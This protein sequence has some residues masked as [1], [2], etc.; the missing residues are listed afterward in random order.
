MRNIGGY[1][2]LLA[3][4][5]TILGVSTSSAHAYLDPGTGSLILQVLLGGIAGVAVAGKM[6]WHKFCT[7][8]GIRQEIEQDNQVSDNRNVRED[9]SHR[10]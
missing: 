4:A 10:E 9:G 7:L 6:Y 1:S 5:A 3:L 8:L 2:V